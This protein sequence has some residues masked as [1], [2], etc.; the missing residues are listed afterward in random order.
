VCVT[1]KGDGDAALGQIINDVQKV[2]RIS[3][4]TIGCGDTENIVLT[5]VGQSFSQLRAHGA[6][7][8]DVLR[9]NL[10]GAGGFQLGDLGF[11]ARTLFK[12]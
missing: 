11:E 2:D 8:G 12:G 7:A 3:C 4:K 10:S 5:N 6:D 9:E 1:P